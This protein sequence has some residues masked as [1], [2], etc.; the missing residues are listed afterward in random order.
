MR[1]AAIS[2]PSPKPV[3]VEQ[4][5]YRKGYM[6]YFEDS[7]T[8]PDAFIEGL[9]MDLVMDSR[10][11]PRPSTVQY[12]AAFL[13][14]CIGVESFT[15]LE[16]GKPVNYEIS[17]QI[18]SGVGKVCI[19][20]DGGTWTIIGGNYATTHWVDFTPGNYRVM[21]SNRINDMSYLD[22]PTLT[23]ITYTG[24]PT[25]TTPTAVVTGLTGTADTQ[26]LRYTGEGDNGETAR[27]PATTY[28]TSKVRDQWAGDN[29]EYV[30]YN[31]TAIAGAKYYNW[32]IGSAS[33]QE[34]YV[35]TTTSP[36]Y[37][38]DGTAGINPIRRAPEGDSTKGPILGTMWYSGGKF[39]GVDD[40]DNPSYVWYSGDGKDAG[41]WSPFLGGGWVAIDYGGNTLP[42]GGLA[43]RDGKGTAAIT[44]LSKGAAGGGQMNHI[45][46]QTQVIGDTPFIYPEV[47][48]AN[49]QAG[50]YGS[51]CIVE[52]NNGIY[53]LT[54]LDIKT[55][56]TVA[57]MVNILV[58]QSVALQIMPDVRN[59]NLSALDGACCVYDDSENCIY[60]AVPNG[61]D[62]NNQIWK[63]DLARGGIWL[64][65]WT[66]AA[67]HLW[68]YEDNDGNTH[69]LALVNNKPMEFTRTVL[70]Q[71]DGVPFNTRFRTV[72]TWDKT[73]QSLAEIDSSTHKF[74]HPV[75][76]INAVS[77]GLDE[78]LMPTGTLAGD[79]F[80]QTVDLT[81]WNE[82]GFNELAWNEE[83]GVPQSLAQSVGYIRL[84]PDETL[85]QLELEITTDSPSDYILA[86]TLTRGDAT[87]EYIGD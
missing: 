59:L 3:R 39:W 68:K 33:G 10:P 25:P 86:S 70:T 64:L 78:D 30:T 71:D 46:F 72:I 11:R 41:S 58:Q 56:N 54:G 57:N 12:G 19:R 49:G 35:A 23:L 69:M 20:K 4:T 38:D 62:E 27:S 85:N 50:A 6:S 29:T 53:Y 45:V 79:T 82:S 84:E 34:R 26:Y 80:I 1:S 22:L 47:Y 16:S 28:Q 81:G 83:Y 24:L 9:N 87:N 74:L 66:I 5:S 40:K 14:E 7:I 13:G 63:Q 15:R 52:A 37:R 65:P 60:W 67:K 61:S 8:P 44:I 77:T 36:T 43:Y 32:Y 75:G 55:T 42:V 21:I 51:R 76:A 2:N 48:P 18:I 17:M 73:G 31:G